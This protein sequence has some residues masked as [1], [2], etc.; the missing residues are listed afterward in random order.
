MSV[1]NKCKAPAGSPESNVFRRVEL[2]DL[3]KLK[4]LKEAIILTPDVTISDHDSQ[5]QPFLL[6]DQAPPICSKTPDESN[7][8]SCESDPLFRSRQS[9]TQ[10]D[11][12]APVP[13]IP[14]S[15][16]IF[17]FVLAALWISA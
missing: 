16:V 1:N 9:P 14:M 13:L 2:T 15:M 17:A 6:K 7:A 3:S 12:I 8:G 4:R 5:P 10:S 11:S